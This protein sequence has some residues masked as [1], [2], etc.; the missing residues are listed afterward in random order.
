MW[1]L[2]TVTIS[3]TAK[4]NRN[5]GVVRWLASMPPDSL[6]TSVL[7]LGELE[8]GIVRMPEGQKRRA[9]E[10]WLRDGFP[11]WFGPRI[12]A[13]DRA[14]AAEWGRLGVHADRRTVDALIA[15]TAKAH[16]LVVV[17]RSTRDFDGLGVPVINP[18]TP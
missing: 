12:H 13:I 2:D 6:H 14:A 16:G 5:P 18:W 4:I 15:A 3:E 9:L 17:T 11:A 10:G 1:L 7:C 8:R